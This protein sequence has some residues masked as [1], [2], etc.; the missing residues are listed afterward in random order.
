MFVGSECIECEQCGECERLSGEHEH[1]DEDE[2]ETL[3]ERE[4]RDE[5][6][7][8]SLGEHERMSARHLVNVSVV[9]VVNVKEVESVTRVM[10]RGTVVSGMEWMTV[11]KKL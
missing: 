7:C 1:R 11:G 4:R 3:G 9:V 10:N 2:C 8:E 6:E 5:D